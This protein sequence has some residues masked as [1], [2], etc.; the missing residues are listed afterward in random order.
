MR[1]AVPGLDPGL[2]LDLLPEFF[3]AGNNAW[4][5]IVGRGGLP[6]SHADF[7]VSFLEFSE[8]RTACGCGFSL[9]LA[10]IDCGTDEETSAGLLMAPASAS[11]P[12]EDDADVLLPPPL[13]PT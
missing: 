2:E 6:L 1:P 11:S 9:A 13:P 4:L 10:A 7:V 12:T 5:L 8:K 3:F